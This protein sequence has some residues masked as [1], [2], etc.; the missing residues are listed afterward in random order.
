VSKAFRNGLVYAIGLTALFGCATPPE[1]MHAAYVSP[2]Q[3]KGMNCTQL[4]EEMERVSGREIELHAQLKEL[5]DDDATQ[6]GVGLILLWPTLFFLEGGDGVQAAEYSR[7]KGEG[8]AI[9]KL[10]VRKSCS[11]ELMEPVKKREVR[12][13]IPMR[14]KELQQLLDDD[15]ITP[16][17]YDSRRSKI[18]DSL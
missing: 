5:A 2:T 10:M 12:G 8:D 16:K 9:K 11:T 7:L 18:L 14:L 17:E 15:T 13:N 6:M 1:E 4:S 3:F